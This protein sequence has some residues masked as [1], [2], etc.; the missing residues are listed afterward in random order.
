M[1]SVVIPGI[2][3]PGNRQKIP[4]SR[5]ANIG[6]RG[7]RTGSAPVQRTSCRVPSPSAAPHAR[8]SSNLP[9]TNT[10]RLRLNFGGM[11]GYSVIKLVKPIK[12][13]GSWMPH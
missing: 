2:V 6:R 10:A 11:G 7:L 9:S 1:L 13:V 5:F 4:A 12:A 8:I 3:L